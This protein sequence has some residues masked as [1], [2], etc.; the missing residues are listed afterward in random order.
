MSSIILKQYYEP[1]LKFSDRCIQPG[2]A[3]LHHYKK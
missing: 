2:S 3:S 1:L